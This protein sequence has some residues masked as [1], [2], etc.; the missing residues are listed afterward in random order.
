M[1]A[2]AL[3]EQLSPKKRTVLVLHDMRGMDASRIAKFAAMAASVLFGK[4]RSLL[5]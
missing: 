3:L 4:A 2:E 1:R 5:G